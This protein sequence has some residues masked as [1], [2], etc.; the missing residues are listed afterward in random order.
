MN[1]LQRIGA[2]AAMKPTTIR[3]LERPIDAL[4]PRRAC[5]SRRSGNSIAYSLQ[6]RPRH[7]D[8]GW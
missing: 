3:F 8:V 7:F 4:M 5:V 2:L 6:E 1:L